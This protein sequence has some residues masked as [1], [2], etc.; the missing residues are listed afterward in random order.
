MSKYTTWEQV[1]QQHYQDEAVRKEGINEENALSLRLNVVPREYAYEQ[2]LKILLALGYD[3]TKSETN[4]S[5]EKVAL[6]WWKRFENS[7]YDLYVYET[8]CTHGVTFRRTPAEVF[9]WT[10]KEQLMY[11]HVQQEPHRLTEKY[12][13]EC[14]G[15]EKVELLEKKFASGP[16][17]EL[18][19]K[20]P[21]KSGEEFHA[22]ILARQFRNQKS[23]FDINMKRF[24]ADRA[25]KKTEEWEAFCKTVGSAPPNSKMHSDLDRWI[26]IVRPFII[27]DEW[28]W[29]DLWS[30]AMKKFQN[31]TSAYPYTNS[32]EF[33]KYVRSFLNPKLEPLRQFQLRSRH[34]QRGRSSPPALPYKF[35]LDMKP[36]PDLLA[37]FGYRSRG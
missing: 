35:A 15:N 37:C 24:L 16:S 33:A 13:V 10:E 27:N 4:S 3:L 1:K 11:A 8:A 21:I 29:Y 34:P 14:L 32:R 22:E 2:T 28:S 25:K 20:L 18:S 9:G 31:R 7:L 17:K 6:C 23:P 5:L 30:A 36:I 12:V 26:L 19:A